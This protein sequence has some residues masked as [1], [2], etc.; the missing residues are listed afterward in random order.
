MANRP[1]VGLNTAGNGS[2]NAIP[3]ADTGT[4]EKLKVGAADTVNGV[5]FADA[6]GEQKTVAGFEFNGTDTMTVPKVALSDG[7]ANGVAYLNGSKVL[8]TGA[9]LQF[10]EAGNYLRLAS[11]GI[12]FNGDT[13]AANALDDYE[14]GVWEPVDASGAG[15]AITFQNAR[16]TKIGN[17]VYIR[18]DQI[19]YPATA[20]GSDAIIGGMPFVNSA[21]DVA[22]AAAV[23]GNSFASRQMIFSNQNYFYLFAFP[24]TTRSTNAQVSSVIIYGFNATYTVA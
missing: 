5:V 2:L 8:T 7:T 3:P 24:S 6:N 9:G 15:L 13:A 1:I 22:A 4:I 10:I 18:A 17:Q 21:G 14:E 20:N 23:A 19:A 16:Y 12:Q 11:G